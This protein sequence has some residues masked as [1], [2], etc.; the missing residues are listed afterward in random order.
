MAR[1]EGGLGVKRLFEKL[2]PQEESDL[3]KKNNHVILYNVIGFMAAS[4]FA[5]NGAIISNVGYLLGEKGLNTC[6]VDFKVFYPTL[7]NYLDVYPNEKGRGLLNI[8]KDDKADIRKHINST[9][10]KQLYLLSPSPYDLIEEYLDFK[11]EHIERVIEKLK[12][13][14]D[15]VII[16]IPNNP[17]LEFCLAAMKYVHRGF[18]TVS[19]RIETIV[20][21]SKLLDFAASIGITTSKFTNLIFVNT[22]ELNYDYGA[23][24]EMNLKIEARL[25]MVKSVTEEYFKGNL[26]IKDSVMINK[27]YMEGIQN[28]VR[29]ICN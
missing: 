24:K 10:Y 16:D 4:E 11:F 22:Q 18:I 25:P 8:L 21:I 23:I 7:Y 20:N 2:T 15:L 27:Q 17:P 1:F 29:T 26:Y 3:E 19:E 14:F 12:E 13:I 28:I 9:K 5:D 6:I